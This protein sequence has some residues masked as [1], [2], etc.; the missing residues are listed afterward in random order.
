MLAERLAVIAGRDHDG[1]GGA[2]AKRV[3]QPPD[4]AIDRRDL[5][6]VAV[7]RPARAVIVP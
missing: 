6:V 2:I 4:L 7:E 1:F 3:Q 5:V